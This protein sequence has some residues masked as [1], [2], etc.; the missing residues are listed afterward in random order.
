MKP[1]YVIYGEEDLFRFEAL[2]ALRKKAKEEGYLNRELL[3]VENHFN[4]D[5]LWYALESQ[6]LFSERKLLEIHIPNGKPGKVGSEQLQSLANKIQQIEDVSIIVFLP[7]LDRSQTQ[8]KWFKKLLEN[9]ES[10]EAK[11][12][13][14]N[15]LPAWISGRLA[16]YHL[17]INQDAL[18]LFAERVEGNLLAANQEI[19]KMALLHE[20]GD[21]IGLDEIQ[22]VIANVARFDIFQM[23]EAW[24]SGD[25]VRLLRLLEG[26][27]LNSAEPVLMV[28]IISEDIRTLIRLSGALKQGKT[29]ASVKNSLRLWGN[30]QYTA[31]KAVQRISTRRLMK[32]LQECANIDIQIKGLESGNVWY[33]IRNLLIDLSK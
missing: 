7:K 33:S 13:Y 26:L 11:T 23:S 3:T 2:D 10:Q 22:S 28:W 12:I 14:P 4:W 19:E 17:K 9:A 20:S 30:K 25:I 8:S 31:Q 21:V 29:I 32:A 6:G 5:D 27:E 24:M 16:R 15:Q 1:L 18:M